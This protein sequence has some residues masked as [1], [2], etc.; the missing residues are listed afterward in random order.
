MLSCF[1][2]SIVTDVIWLSFWHDQPSYSTAKLFQTSL[3]IGRWLL[4]ISSYF[5][6]AKAFSML[7]DLWLRWPQKCSHHQ[8]I[9]DTLSASNL[10]PFMEIQLPTLLDWWQCWVHHGALV[11]PAC[12]CVTVVH[13]WSAPSG[14]IIQVCAA[15]GSDRINFLRDSQYGALFW[16]YLKTV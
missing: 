3:W 4:Y 13:L 2:I 1:S 12:L 7:I 8:C 11:F 10:P 14:C 16:I 6:W 5:T 15:F 9:M